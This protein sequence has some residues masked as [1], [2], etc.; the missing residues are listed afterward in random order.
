MKYLETKGVDMAVELGPQTVL[1]NLMKRN[2]P[3]IPAFSFDNEDDI[4]L[5][6]RKLSN[7]ENKAGEGSGN[8]LKFLKMCLATAVSTKNTNWNEEE[9]AKGVVEPYRRIQ[10]IKEE[11]ESNSYE[12]SFEQI[13]EAAEML[14]HIFRTKGVDLKEQRERFETISKET[15]FESLFEM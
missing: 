4:L 6:E 5:L 10:K 15:G 1:R 14:K 7:T 13:K 12:P 3:G 9:Y 8:G 11:M 2:V